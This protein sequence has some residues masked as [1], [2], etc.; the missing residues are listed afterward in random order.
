MQ[1]E[2][3]PNAGK[4]L[5][6]S[7]GTDSYARLPI[8]THII[9]DQ[10]DI[11]NV[12]ARYASPHLAPG[13]VL[14]ISER[15]VAISQGRAYPISEIKPSPL[16]K[17]LVKFVHKSPHGIGLGSPWTMELALREAG[18]PRM[19]L[20]AFAAALTKPFGVRGVFYHV[21]G[22]NINAI[23][24]PCDYTLPPYNHY[25]KLG[26]KDP[27]DVAHKLAAV[28]GHEV[29]IIDANDLGVAILGRSEHAPDEA[30]C[31]QV[32][33]DNP[34]GQTDERTPLCVVRKIR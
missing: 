2:L 15:V 5:T 20:A 4:G 29:V 24:G 26:P 34:L 23:D 13:D 3:Q 33:R 30:F 11:A 21:V 17:L 19:L 12:C 27:D 18:A 9:T 25:A 8:Q 32:F 28:L 1:S 31:K 22:N 7:V 10:D 6:I 16:A 14:F